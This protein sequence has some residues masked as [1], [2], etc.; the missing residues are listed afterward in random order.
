MASKSV[1]MTN[2]MTPPK[3]A[4]TL[5]EEIRKQGGLALFVGG[6]VRDSVFNSLFERK[7]E[8][9]D[10]DIE[11][12][13]M[14]FTDLRDILEQYGKVSLVGAQFGILDFVD[15][16]GV[17]LDFSLP[18]K[19]NRIGIKRQEFS[20]EVDECMT[21][22]QASLR[23]DYT[24]NSMAYDWIAQTLIDPHGGVEDIKKKILRPISDK[25]S[26]DCLRVLRGMQLAG[27]FEMTLDDSE[28]TREMC[29]RLSTE[30]HTLPED[31]IRDEWKKW[32]ESWKPSMGLRFLRDAGWLPVFP[33]LESLV[34]IPQDPVWHPEGWNVKSIDY[35]MCNKNSFMKCL[36]YSIENFS[37]VPI[38]SMDEI[39]VLGSIDYKSNDV[40]RVGI[41]LPYNSVR[42]VVPEMTK[43]TI[44][45]SLIQPVATYATSLFPVLDD[46]L[47]LVFNI[48]S[49]SNKSVVFTSAASSISIPLV[50]IDT[51]DV[52]SE[53]KDI[54]IFFDVC[55][56]STGEIHEEVIIHHLKVTMG[57]VWEHTLYTV[58]AGAEICRRENVTGS[59]RVKIIIADLC[60]DLGK[61]ATTQF[62]EGHFRAHSHDTEGEQP[63]RSFLKRAGFVHPHKKTATQFVEDIVS[64]VVFHMQHVNF[65]GSIK[66][67]KRLAN[68]VNIAD[69]AL[70]VESDHSG[71]PPIPAGMPTQMKEML[72]MASELAIESAKPQPI[73]KGRNLVQIGL[74]PS[75][76]FTTILRAAMEAQLDGEFETE[77][78]GIQ[79]VS[80]YVQ[81]NYDIPVYQAV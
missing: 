41:T 21:I 81:E 1:I 52:S 9:N 43:E 53:N 45:T 24:V 4:I 51:R 49:L 59:R 17:C 56:D 3:I 79:W 11:V 36:I 48:D 74:K 33:E 54:R 27:R 20:I 68:K 22:E 35:H 37:G 13:N 31:R 66:Q 65:S 55:M 75:E 6:C 40:F 14:P 34:G 70:V 67:V 42:Q 46:T 72:V 69:L 44:L 39:W 7:V 77:Q 16:N 57:D 71:R 2:L 32:A 58:D 10:Y 50:V 61:P 12:Y 63:T 29:K 64:L 60:H 5:I 18:R 76:M 28:E 25:F 26:E 8:I 23:R 73:I 19:E 47:D 80:N 62:M 30:F 15:E 38:D 78:D